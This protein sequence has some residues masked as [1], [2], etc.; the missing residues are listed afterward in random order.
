M[1]WPGR[2]GQGGRSE[3]KRGGEKKA[4][5]L[6]GI[7][8]DKEERTGRERKKEREEKGKKERKKKKKKE[9]ERKK[10]KGKREKEKGKRERKRKKKKRKNEKKKNRKEKERCT[11]QDK[12]NTER[13]AERERKN[14]QMYGHNH[15]GNSAN[16]TALSHSHWIRERTEPRNP[17]LRHHKEWNSTTGKTVPKRGATTSPAAR[18]GEALRG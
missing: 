10:K 4:K 7:F 2:G 5:G 17:I 6:E 8:P 18:L 16:T 9:K 1:Q 15:V 14:G 11:Q 12:A 3:S 13:I